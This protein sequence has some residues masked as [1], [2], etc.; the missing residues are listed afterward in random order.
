MTATTTSGLKCLF[1]GVLT[2]PLV[3]GNGRNQARVGRVG[4]RLSRAGGVHSALVCR[5]GVGEVTGSPKQFRCRRRCDGDG[6]A[7]GRVRLGQYLWEAV[8]LLRERP[9]RVR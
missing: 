2:C 3:R 5:D 7:A 9:R 1:H 8:E 6:L 4:Q